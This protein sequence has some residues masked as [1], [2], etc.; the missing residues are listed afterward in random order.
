MNDIMQLGSETVLLLITP[1][2]GRL[3][4]PIVRM[5][6]AGGCAKQADASM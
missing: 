4:S 3:N 1:A 2:V 6:L 5:S